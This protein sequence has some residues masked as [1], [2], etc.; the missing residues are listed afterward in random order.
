[1]TIR[2]TVSGEIGRLP[3]KPTIVGG[4][5]GCVGGGPV[6]YRILLTV[7]WYICSCCAEDVDL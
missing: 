2:R 6:C 3:A 7:G 1:M 5:V 4:E